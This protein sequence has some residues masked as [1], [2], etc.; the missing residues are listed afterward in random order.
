M[1]TIISFE[2]ATVEKL[3]GADVIMTIDWGDRQAPAVL[4]G[5]AAF[6]RAAMNAETAA[7][8][9]ILRVSISTNE[10][11]EELKTRIREGK[12]KLEASHE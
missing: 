8:T 7:E 9:N 4:L 10:E 11:F 1:I 5:G 3:T 12:G 2:E 6:V